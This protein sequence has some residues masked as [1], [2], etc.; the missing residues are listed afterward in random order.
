MEDEKIIDLYWDRDQS[1]ILK[2]EEKYG[3]YC[4]RIAWNILYNKEDCEECIN[5]TWMRAWNAMPTERPNILSAFLGAIT[6]NLSL[7][8]YRKQHAKKRGE[9]EVAFVF[10]ELQDCLMAEGPE[11]QMD[12]NLLVDA[13]NRFLERMEK[14]NRIIFVRRYWY[15]DS[16]DAIAKR[17]SISES[18][19]KSSLFRSRN[20]LRDYLQ[21]EGFSI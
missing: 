5:D 15:M 3:S 17:F 20:K 1:A 10:D 9:G 6:R 2:T 7:D 8:R 11:Q 18:K 21:Q 12:A 14:E 4:H 16:I 13:L 19:V